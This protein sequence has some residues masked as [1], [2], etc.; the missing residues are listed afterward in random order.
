MLI[1][2]IIE[3]FVNGLFIL[4]TNEDANEIKFR[5]HLRDFMVQLK[6]RH[7]YYVVDYFCLLCL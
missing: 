4:S 1:S 5:V 2:Q 3:A 6:V 7:S